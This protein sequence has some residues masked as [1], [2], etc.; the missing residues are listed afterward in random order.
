[1]YKAGY[2]DAEDRGQ[3]RGFVAVAAERVGDECDRDAR[4]TSVVDQSLEPRDG[5]RYCSGTARQNAVHV[6]TDSERRLYKVVHP[7]Q[8]TGYS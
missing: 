5:G 4:L 8:S 6:E 1:M 3:V 7:S 2:L